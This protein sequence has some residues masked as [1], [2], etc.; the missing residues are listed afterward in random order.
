MSIIGKFCIYSSKNKK[1]RRVA[2][3]GFFG[4]RV[5]GSARDDAYRSAIPRALDIELHPA[6]DFGE[7]RVVL[8]DAD[9][10]AGV[11]FGAALAHQ[12]VARQNLFAGITLDA[13]AL[14]VGIPTVA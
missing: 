4:A 2:R 10:H 8:A 14:R 1:P 3:A 5:S 6:V 13:E 11:K 9:V 7:Q 12:N